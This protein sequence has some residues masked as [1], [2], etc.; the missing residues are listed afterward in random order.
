MNLPLE[1]DSIAAYAKPRRWLTYRP[2]RLARN[3]AAMLAGLGFRTLAQGI[4]FILVARALGARGYGEFVA[5]LSVA[6]LFS[7]LVGLGATALMIRETARRPE[8]FPEE[9]GRGLLM[10]GMTGAP[11]LGLALLAGFGLLGPELSWRILLPVVLAELICAPLVEFS[12]CAFQAFERMARMALIFIAPVALRLTG[13][14]SLLLMAEPSSPE[15]WAAAYLAASALAALGAVL[16]AGME[17]GRPRLHFGG[18]LKAAREGFFF[19]LG[20]ASHRV[21]ADI[22]KALLARLDSAGAAGLYSAA[23]RFAEMTLIPIQALLSASIARF[24]RAGANGTAASARYA[25]ALLPFPAAYAF[26]A[27]LGLFLLSGVLP[28]LLGAG[29]T[30]SAEIVRWLAWLPLVSLIRY[31]LGTVAGV[32]GRQRLSGLVHGLGAGLNAA[33]NVLWIPLWGWQGAVLATFATEGLMILALLLGTARPVKTI[34]ARGA[35]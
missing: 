23:Y 14:L 20:G 11:F 1:P 24:F 16:L 8:A 7:P 12:G 29:F 31:F 10:I 6:T 25:L 30:E 4:L 34:V 22:D 2:G 13:F 9:F 17:L 26:L 3:T 21:Q 32:S 35:Q 15:T 18:S 28:W 33:F 5:A 27:G 19:A